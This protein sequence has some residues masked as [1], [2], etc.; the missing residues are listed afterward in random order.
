MWELTFVVSL[1]TRRIWEQATGHICSW[2]MSVLL[3]CVNESSL[4]DSI[5]GLGNMVSG[6]LFLA[7]VRACVRALPVISPRGYSCLP[8]RTCVCFYLKLVFYLDFE[9]IV[10]SIRDL[11]YKKNMSE[12]L[13]WCPFPSHVCIC[14][15]THHSDTV[16]PCYSS[17][18]VFS[19]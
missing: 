10:S 6:K 13:I 18:V 8:P 5:I 16:E 7:C 4:C 12:H 9:S 17:L 19:N 11:R 1:H 2:F 14:F 15:L 3:M